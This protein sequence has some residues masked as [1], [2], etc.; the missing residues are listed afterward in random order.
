MFL[1]TGNHCQFC[2]CEATI[3][4]AS[5]HSLILKIFKVREKWGAPLAPCSAALAS[6]SLVH[7]TRARPI[8]AP[9]AYQCSDYKLNIYKQL[10]K[11]IRCLKDVI[12]FHS[13]FATQAGYYQA[14]V[15]KP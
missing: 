11:W 6:F 2:V 8:Y 13:C 15:N 3:L 1:I 4:F 14:P 10:D 12:C 5:Q 9:A 7:C